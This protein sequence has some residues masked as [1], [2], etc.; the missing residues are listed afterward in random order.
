MKLLKEREREILS[1]CQ[2]PGSP[3]ANVT[4]G[5]SSTLCRNQGTTQA[6]AQYKLG[7]EKE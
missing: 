6:L 2:P 5:E 3:F 7:S 4:I 1:T